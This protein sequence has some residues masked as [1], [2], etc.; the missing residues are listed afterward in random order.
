MEIY[1]P[2][3]PL[4]ETRTAVKLNITWGVSFDICFPLT[5][6]FNSVN[7]ITNDI[8]QTTQNEKKNSNS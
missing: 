6:L 4:V 3:N 8:D 5:V 7:I 1:S 2:V